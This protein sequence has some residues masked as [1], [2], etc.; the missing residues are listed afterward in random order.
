MR[1]LV[2]ACACVACSAADAP[3]TNVAAQS[4]DDRGA[5]VA[6]AQRCI[7]REHMQTVW[8]T[9]PVFA[10]ASATPRRDRGRTWIVMVPE[11]G[12]TASGEVRLLG[13]PRGIGVEV[14]LDDKSCKRLLLE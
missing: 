11:S 6:L 3:D 5:A 12:R 7:E 13:A 14:N 10:Q 8:G 4:A 1:W 9:A 2:L